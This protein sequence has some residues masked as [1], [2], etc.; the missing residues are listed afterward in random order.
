MTTDFDQFVV[1]HEFFK[2]EYDHLYV[3]I[4]RWYVGCFKFTSEIMKLKQL[5]NNRFEVKNL[6]PT[7]QILKIDIQKDRENDIWH[8]SIWV[9]SRRSSTWMS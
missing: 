8:I 1:S 7:K 2:S 9:I 3:V 5:I 6:G 4:Y